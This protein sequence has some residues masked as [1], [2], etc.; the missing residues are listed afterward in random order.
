M[1]RGALRTVNINLTVRLLVYGSGS[2]TSKL[3]GLV[4][5][6]IS[7]QQRAVELDEDVLDLLLALLIDILLVVGDQRLGK[8]L[9]DGVDLGHVATA[10]HT[11]ADVDVSKPV[12]SKKQNWLHDPC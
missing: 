6:G 3:L 5:S 1:Y 4:S 11:N 10:L 9:P 8:S 2:G 12:L 7:D